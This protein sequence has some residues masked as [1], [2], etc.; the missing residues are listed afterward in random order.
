MYSKLTFGSWLKFFAVVLIVGVVGCGSDE[1]TDAQVKQG[2][3]QMAVLQNA[4][5]PITTAVVAQDA[6]ALKVKEILKS[7]RRRSDPPRRWDW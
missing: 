2:A 1:E 6:T 5:L 4:A 7:R 3:A